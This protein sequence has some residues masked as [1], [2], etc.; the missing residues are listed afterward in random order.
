VEISALANLTAPPRRKLCTRAGSG[1]SGQAPADAYSVG[2]PT[3][4]LVLLPKLLEPQPRDLARGYLWQAVPLPGPIDGLLGAV[5]SWGPIPGWM[6]LEPAPQGRPDP[7][8][9]PFS[10]NGAG[11]DAFSKQI[12]QVESRLRDPEASEVGKRRI[13][14]GTNANYLVTLSNGVSAI[15]TPKASE[16]SSSSQRPNVPQGTQSQ[17]EEAAYLV[18]RKLGHLARVPPAVC[19]GLEGRE[20]SLKLLVSQ[21]QDAARKGGPQQEIGPADQRRIAIFDHVIGNLDRHSGNY[22]LDPDGRPI[23]IDHGLA[24]PV[25]NGSQGFTNFHFD[26]SFQLDPKEKAL[27]AGFLADRQAVEAEL[28]SLLE[29]EAIQAMFER[30]E[31]MLELGW[32]SH[33]WRQK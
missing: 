5:L 17:R 15:W 1:T 32:I 11:G 24:F 8:P 22:L 21:A 18:D 25:K 26:A 13:L 14:G 28:K 20:G 30:V 31:R 29:P 6:G 23:P 10:W 33:E 12:E 3:A 2:P 9:L 4:P 7:Q 19:S 16:R 27:L